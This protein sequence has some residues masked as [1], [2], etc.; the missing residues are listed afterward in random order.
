MFFGLYFATTGLHLVHLTVGVV[1]LLA[2]A[3]QVWRARANALAD[4]VEV[5]GL[6]WH[7]VDVVWI[8]LYPCLYLISRS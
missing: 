6:Y 1:V 3:R 5:A 2:L 7:F 4:H 8:F